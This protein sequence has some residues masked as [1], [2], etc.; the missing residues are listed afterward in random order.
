MGNIP[1]ARLCRFEDFGAGVAQLATG[2]R[3]KPS[4]A[5]LLSVR[6]FLKRFPYDAACLDHI[7][8]VWY[9]MRH[10]CD[11]SLNI[12]EVIEPIR[13]CRFSKI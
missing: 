3:A 12:D 4:E 6:E 10:P 11:K 9:G 5:Q 1:L 13:F 7:M 2:H 8:S